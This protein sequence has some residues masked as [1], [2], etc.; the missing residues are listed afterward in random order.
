MM[1]VRSVMLWAVIGAAGALA[2][3]WVGLA[4]RRYSRTARGL[5]ERERGELRGWFSEELLGRVR[6]A[7]V[8]E[9]RLPLTRVVGWVLGSAMGGALAGPG[10][11]ALGELVVVRRG[12]GV[13]VLFHEC[14]H[15]AQYRALGTRRFL[16]AYLR[17]WWAAG[18]DYWGIPLEEQ[19]YGLQG[20]FEGGGEVVSVESEIAKS[21]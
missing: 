13:G 10:G 7:E 6:V 19:A 15:V 17:G 8:D 16:S 2:A 20:E 4:R 12:G 1:W 14:V 18:R 5:T 11:I 21:K 3:A 9:V